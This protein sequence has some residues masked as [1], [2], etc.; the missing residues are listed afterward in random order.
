MIK[1]TKLRPQQE[2]QLPSPSPRGVWRPS[3]EAG[4]AR[5]PGL[6]PDAVEAP[7]RTASLC[8]KERLPP[9]AGRAEASE[10][11]PQAQPLGTEEPGLGERGSLRRLSRDCRRPW[12]DDHAVPQL[13]APQLVLP[14]VLSRSS[15]IPLC[16]RQVAEGQVRTRSQWQGDQQGTTSALASYTDPDLHTHTL[17]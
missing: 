4:R 9:R 5:S 11:G 6:A 15:S 10:R 16:T 17:L 3:R 8:C 2:Q 1:D 12:A 14:S 7:P 13:P